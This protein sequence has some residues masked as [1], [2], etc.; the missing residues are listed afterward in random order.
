MVRSMKA[1]APHAS[2]LAWRIPG[3]A[4]PDGL[5]FMGLQRVGH[6]WSDLTA[7]ASASHVKYWGKR[8]W[9]YEKLK[10]EIF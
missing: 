6:D 5:P 2:T 3:M 4:E 8:E 7:A 10:E 1:M 9:K